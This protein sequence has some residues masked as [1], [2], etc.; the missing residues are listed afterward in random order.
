MSDRKTTTELLS[1]ILKRTRLTGLGKYAA[2]EVTLDYG[3]SNQKRVDF[4]QFKPTQTFTVSGIEQGSFIFYEVKSC[5]AD[6]YSGN[7]LNFY[8]DQNY[9]VMDME[10]WKSFME[11][12]Q[13]RSTKFM[14]WYTEGHPDGMHNIGIMVAKPAGR[15]AYDELLDPTELT[16][17][18]YNDFELEVI[19]PSRTQ[20]RKRS[21]AEL[22]F[23]MLRSGL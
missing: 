19:I 16:E 22:L 3:S 17:E 18:N 23:C 13:Q 7:G 15:D 21:V 6:I 12:F 4:V 20:P 5:K 10:T 1:E 9:I 14:D 11:D 8:G 2:S